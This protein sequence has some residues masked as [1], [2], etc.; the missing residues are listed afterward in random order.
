MKYQVIRFHTERSHLGVEILLSYADIKL[1][2][3]LIININTLS[4]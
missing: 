3:H 2:F 1:D 4:D